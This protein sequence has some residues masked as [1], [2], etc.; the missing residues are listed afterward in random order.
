MT[1]LSPDRVEQV[2]QTLQSAIQDIPLDANAVE[3]AMALQQLALRAG[4]NVA[5]PRDLARGL[6]G[7][8]ERLMAKARPPERQAQ[9]VIQVAQEALGVLVELLRNHGASDAAIRELILGYVLTWIGR[10]EPVGAAELLYRHAD[11]LAGRAARA[12]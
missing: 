4:E 9:T 3:V 1:G 7:Q 5:E 12:H 6:I 10:S 11:A 8:A 2:V